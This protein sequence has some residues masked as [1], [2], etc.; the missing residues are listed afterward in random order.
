M[1]LLLI[2]YLQGFPWPPTPTTAI[3]QQWAYWMS[4]RR[5][6]QK[7]ET[8]ARQ[9]CW[10]GINLSSLMTNFHSAN[11]CIV[12]DYV[13]STG[14]GTVTASDL[15]L[16]SHPNR[17]W[18]A[19]LLF[20]PLLKLHSASPFIYVFPWTRNVGKFSPPWPQPSLSRGT[21]HHRESIFFFL[22]IG[23]ENITFNPLCR[24]SIGGKM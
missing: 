6:K 3:T 9:L 8:N 22:Y 18:P 23:C 15:S 4:A 2:R 1:A 17:A 12:K 11:I 14:L 21:C 20:H 19:Q 5:N 7:R 13:S 24:R 16:P 10:R